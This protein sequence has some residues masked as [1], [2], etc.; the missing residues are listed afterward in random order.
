MKVVRHVNIRGHVQG[1][2]FRY[3][4]VQRVR[5]ILDHDLALEGWVRNRRDG[6]VEALF[7]GEPGVVAD[8]I[9]ACRKGPSGAWVE[10]I[11]EREGDPTQLDLRLAG[12]QFSMLATA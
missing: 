5:N 8:I 6:S 1:V 9:A 12:Q 7:A 2:G 11:D 10:S 4:V 3:F